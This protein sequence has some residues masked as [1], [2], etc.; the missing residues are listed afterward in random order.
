MAYAVV[1][2]FSTN[3]SLLITAKPLSARPETTYWAKKTNERG[4][5]LAI[6]TL[7]AKMGPTIA[8]KRDFFISSCA[9]GKTLYNKDDFFQ[10]RCWAQFNDNLPHAHRVYKEGS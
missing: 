3:S 4:K 8:K 6:I 5:E 9:T 2:V 7:L 10:H 1:G